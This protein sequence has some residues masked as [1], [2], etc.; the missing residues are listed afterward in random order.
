MKPIG[1]ATTTTLATAG[2]ATGTPHGGHG[3]A[4]PESLRAAA[5]LAARRPAEVD[6]AALSRA[7]L[8]GAELTVRYETR[9]PQGPNGE[10]LGF[11]QVATGCSVD[12]DPEARES[13]LAEIRKFL[14]P[15]PQREIE[16][17]LAELSVIVAKRQG[18]EFEESL[19]VAAYAS[20]L[21]AYPADVAR[22]AL[23]GRTWKFWPCWEELSKVCNQLASPRKHMELA[24]GKPPAPR[25]EERRPRTEEERE[26]QRAMIADL[27]RELTQG[28]ETP[29]SGSPA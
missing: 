14:T 25:D 19:R 4:T 7:S 12:G 18:D 11:Y 21:A 5:W 1:S 10:R 15:A 29:T 2:S 16:A 20:R 8:H 6:Q 27:L 23:L 26:R 24:L 13:A 17:W 3:S 28:D 22:E 9:F